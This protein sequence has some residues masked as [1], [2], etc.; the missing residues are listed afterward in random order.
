MIWD[1]YYWLKR[2]PWDS[3]VTPPELVELV[4]RRFREGGRALDIGCGTGT[5]VV[6]LAQHGFEASGIDVSRRAIALARR[7]AKQMRVAVD[8][9][10]GSATHLERYARL[11]DFDLALDIGCLHVLSFEGRQAYAQGLLERVRP[12][13][14]YL[15]YAF[16]PVKRG[17]RMMGVAAD[18]IGSL[19]AAG[20]VVEDLLIGEDSV[21]RHSSAWYTLRRT[22]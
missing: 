7:R 1:L 2:T 21:A 6:Y 17:R 9:Q 12:G 15:L 11:G 5:N 8:L 10:V 22:G 16:C 4:A 3:G 20:F 13:G 19:F 18:E 14:L